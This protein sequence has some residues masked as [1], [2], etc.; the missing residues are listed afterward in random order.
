MGEMVVKID[1]SVPGSPIG[2]I[3]TS[4][5]VSAPS[6]AP[7]F[8]SVAPNPA[9]KGAY[10]FSI[11]A[12][13]GVVAANNFISIFNPAASGKTV[14]L[15]AAYVSSFALAADL[16]PAPMNGFRI[17]A[18]SAGTLVTNSTTVTKF[19]STMPDSICEVRTG[20]P[21]VTLGPQIFNAAPVVAPGTGGSTTQNI[22][23]APAV[24]PPFTLVPGEGVVLRT[25][26]GLVATLWNLSLVWAEL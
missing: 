9:I 2:V 20:N 22:A 3:G 13:P 4:L 11:G 5:P 10:V 21:T 14:S 23:A 7:I 15:G 26:S 1:G 19:Q 25:T 18:A 12:V 24:F 16:S 17:T 6:S 8:T